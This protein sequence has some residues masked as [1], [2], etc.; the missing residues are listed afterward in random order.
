MM[1]YL[2]G[3][4]YFIGMNK[5]L[6]VNYISEKKKFIFCGLVIMEGKKCGIVIIDIYNDWLV[7]GY[8]LV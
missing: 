2:L 3:F 5:K 1:G 6:Y 8:I 4:L 7:I